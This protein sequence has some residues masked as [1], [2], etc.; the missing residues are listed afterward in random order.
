MCNKGDLT[1]EIRKLA[2]GVYALLTGIGDPRGDSNFGLITGPGGVMLIDADIRR[3][4]EIS[5][6]IRSVT[7]RPVRYLI[8][9]HDNF[10]H[11]SANTLLARKPVRG[12]HQPGGGR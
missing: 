5:G 1:M 11:T 3:W 8:N 6:L 4:E 9:T 10:D 2:R 12:K 7:D